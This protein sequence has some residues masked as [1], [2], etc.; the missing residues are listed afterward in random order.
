MFKG[1]PPPFPDSNWTRLETAKSREADLDKPAPLLEGTRLKR[2]G[3]K[4][5]F[6]QVLT[7]L[8]EKQAL[9]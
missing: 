9:L 6:G 3:R 1:N 8:S 2:N 7:E 5:I 4:L